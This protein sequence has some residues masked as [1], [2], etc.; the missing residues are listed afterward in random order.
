MTIEAPHAR[1]R[2]LV[3]ALIPVLSASPAYAEP[4]PRHDIAAYCH[5]TEATDTLPGNAEQKYEACLAHE[6]RYLADLERDWGSLS[7]KQQS[8]CVRQEPHNRGYMDI[9]FCA[10]EILYRRAKGFH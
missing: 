4:L 9:N 10:W 2:A 5:S 3:I 8:M 7:E 1:V 6:R